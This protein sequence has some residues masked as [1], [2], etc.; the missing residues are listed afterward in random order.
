MNELITI[1]IRDL[2]NAAEASSRCSSSSWN[3]TLGSLKTAK[4]PKLPNWPVRIGFLFIT[5]SNSLE[6]KHAAD[7]CDQVQ[8]TLPKEINLSL[9][10][11]IE[12]GFLENELR[13]QIFLLD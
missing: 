3:G 2:F 12:D 7:I 11:R 4:F 13:L 10:I 1:E 6:I 9:G 8:A 5:G